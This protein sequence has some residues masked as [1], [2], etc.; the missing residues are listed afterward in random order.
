MVCSSV[1][2]LGT[3]LRDTSNGN[4][5]GDK[6]GVVTMFLSIGVLTGL[7]IGGNAFANLSSNAKARKKMVANLY[8]MTVTM[9]YTLSFLA[10]PFIR[11]TIHSSTAV[12]LLQ[13]AASFC[14]GAGVAVQVYCIPAIVSCTFG[15]NKGL[16][17][18]YTDGVACIVSSIVWRIVGNAVE[19]GNPQGTGWFY[20]WAAVA[21]LVIL[22]GLLMVEF[23]EHYFCRGGSL[24]RLQNVN[25]YADSTYK[26]TATHSTDS[27][28]SFEN[29]AE[30]GKRL[31]E[32]RPSFLRPSA[33]FV[34]VGPEVE[35]ILSIGDDDDD[36]ASTIVFEDVSLP[37]DFSDIENDEL[38][39]DPNDIKQQLKD[40]LEFQGNDTCVDCQA[41]Y[42]R[43]VSII[44]PN[45]IALTHRGASK[46][47]SH[48]IGC[49]CCN[50]CA[51]IHRKLG[52]HLVFVRSVDHDSFKVKELVALRRG[53]N[54]RVN[55]IYEALLKD[56][57]VKPSPASIPSQRDRFIST[58]YEKKLWYK[59]PKTQKVDMSEN[60]M[61]NDAPL[62]TIELVSNYSKE[63]HHVSAST[64]VFAQPA[65]FDKKAHDEYI[66]FVRDDVTV[67]TIPPVKSKAY[68]RKHDEGN[69]ISSDDSEDWHIESN[70]TRG[71]DD[72]INL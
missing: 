38:S 64:S 27:N 10:L 42:P 31:W 34:K 3:Y 41:P 66:S 28:R 22:A 50:E 56:R 65:P 55:E 32:S 7:A 68:N 71:L 37:V 25:Q 35:S 4:I 53:G 16:Y 24:G 12:A 67:E 13:V 23:V 59:A 69:S 36:D 48:E 45:R 46:P 58:K 8:I 29:L 52:T 54:R 63:H 18:S 19:E 57:S 39:R 15:A 2:I 1:R 5:S 61:E 14:M 40:L 9:C 30:S 6:A 20:G 70:E 60:F 49:V 43:W 44:L 17:T 26:H 47:L 33:S 72:L 11:K 51:G 21:L 62:T